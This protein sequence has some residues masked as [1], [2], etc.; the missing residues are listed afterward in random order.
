MGV[1]KLHRLIE[2][3]GLDALLASASAIAPGLQAWVV[4]RDG[5]AVGGAPAMPAI[6]GGAWTAPIVVDGA[7]IGT[8]HVAGKDPALARS[9][10]QLIARAI[11]LAA[12][13]GLGRRVVTAAAIDD[14][15][16]L[17][18]LSRLA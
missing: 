18:L 11:E 4:D 14:L 13:Q 7:E 9:V 3:S 12:T 5:T 15:R 2:G 6:P 1:P 17:A 10:G 16:E 8:V